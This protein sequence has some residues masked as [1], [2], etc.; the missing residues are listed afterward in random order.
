MHPT[1]RRLEQRSHLQCFTLGRGPS[2][3][4]SGSTAYAVLL[5]SSPTLNLSHHARHSPSL[6]CSYGLNKPGY[7]RTARTTADG[8][9]RVCYSF[10][11]RVQALHLGLCVPDPTGYR[12]PLEHSRASSMQCTPCQV[13]L[14]RLS[15]PLEVPVGRMPDLVRYSTCAFR[16][17]QQT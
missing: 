9:T 13:T 11:R 6:P 16:G 7:R 14:F 5:S 12:H 4:R 8:R 17:R 2:F 1:A 3:G 10:S 15:A